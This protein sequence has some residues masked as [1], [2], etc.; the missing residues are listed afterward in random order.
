MSTS[1]VRLSAVHIVSCALL[2]QSKP[3]D[4]LPVFTHTSLLTEEMLGSKT[5]RSED[6]FVSYHASFCFPHGHECIIREI[7]SD[8][9]GRTRAA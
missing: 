3:A 9:V 1:S 4:I 8:G 5:I 7:T 6:G 2:A